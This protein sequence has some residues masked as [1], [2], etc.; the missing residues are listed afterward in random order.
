M[1]AC[2][3][4]KLNYYKLKTL[5]SIVLSLLFY[6]AFCQDTILLLT[7]KTINTKILSIDETGLYLLYQKNGKSKVLNTEYIYSTTD[8][9]GQTTIFYKPD[10]LYNSVDIAFTQEE[11]LYFIKG[12]QRGNNDSHSPIAMAGS[13]VVGVGSAYF[14]LFKIVALSPVYPAAYSVLVGFPNPSIEKIQA[15]YPELSKKEPFVFG[16][17]EAVKSKRVKKSII[18]GLSGLV[19]GVVSRVIIYS[20]YSANTK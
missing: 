19:V 15:K 5:L 10:T 16:Y 3:T 7:G 4:D 9:L 20:F 13:I 17:Q 12:L 8:S 11:M 18:G 6:Q 14:P 1:F 2:K